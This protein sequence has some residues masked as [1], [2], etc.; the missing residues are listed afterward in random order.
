MQSE[1]LHSILAVKMM[2]L[3]TVHNKLGIRILTK[4]VLVTQI[5]LNNRVHNLQAIF[6]II[7]I[8]MIQMQ[9]LIQVLKNYAMMVSIMTEMEKL[10]SVVYLI[11]HQEVGQI[12]LEGHIQLLI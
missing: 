5:I 1:Y 2:P 8:L 10:T 6:R 12:I 3:M 4:M 9:Q 7:L 11:K